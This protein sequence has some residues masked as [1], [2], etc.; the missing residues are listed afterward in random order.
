MLSWVSGAP[1]R[2]QT[3][4]KSVKKLLS[5]ICISEST[6]YTVAKRASQFWRPLL[7]RKGAQLNITSHFPTPLQSEHSY[8][9]VDQRTSSSGG[10]NSEVALQLSSGSAIHF[11]IGGGDI[12]EKGIALPELSCRTAAE[13]PLPDLSP[14]TRVYWLW[15]CQRRQTHSL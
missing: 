12:E 5:E 3:L 2:I 11:S 10:G 6:P 4:E 15:K 7:R 8:D 9:F 13:L 14:T 1:K